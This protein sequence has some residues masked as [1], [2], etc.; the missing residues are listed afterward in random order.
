MIVPVEETPEHLR[1]RATVTGPAL[2]VVGDNHLPGWEARVDGA[3]APVLRADYTLRGVA[4]EPGA[5]EVELAYRPRPVYAGAAVSA[6]ALALTAWLWRA[7]RRRDREDGGT[8]A[9]A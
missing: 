9:A 2:L 3:R 1:L 8:P 5:H 7:A 4:L 6:A